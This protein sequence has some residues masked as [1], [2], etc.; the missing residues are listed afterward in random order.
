MAYYT[1]KNN[2]KRASPLYSSS[3]QE[4][5]KKQKERI[6]RERRADLVAKQKEARKNKKKEKFTDKLRRKWQ[7]RQDR[8]DYMKEIK[9]FEKENQTTYFYN[10]KFPSLKSSNLVR[11]LKLL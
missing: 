2:L 7:E 5:Q 8:K 6:A 9:K 10:F 11:I 4:N 1:S 3:K